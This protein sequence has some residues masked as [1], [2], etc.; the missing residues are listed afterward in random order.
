MK[1]IIYPLLFAVLIFSLF[2]CAPVP[3]TY[4]P[5]IDRGNNMDQAQYWQDLRE[6]RAYAAK[7]SPANQ[8]AGEALAGAAFGAALGAILGSGFGNAGRCAGIGAGSG[9]LSGA[10]H[11]AGSAIERQKAIIRNCMRGRGYKVLE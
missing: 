8:A 2:A 10:A 4:E 9:G 7:I 6:C 11:G 3:S 5:I 1:G